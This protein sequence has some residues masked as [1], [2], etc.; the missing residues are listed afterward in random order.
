MSSLLHRWSRE[1]RRARLSARRT[2]VRSPFQK[3]MHDLWVVAKSLVAV[4]VVWNLVSFVRYVAHDNG[5]TTSQRMATWG[6]NHYMGSFIDWME[7]RVYSTPPSKDPAKNLALTAPTLAPDPTTT[8]APAG[9]KPNTPAGPAPTTT[10]APVAAIGPAPVAPEPI[11]PQI[12]PALAGEGQ[13]TPIARAAGHDTIWATSV[14][15]LAEAGG[16]VAT[17]VEIDQT[18]LRTGLFN[19]AEEPGGTWKRANRVPGELQPALLAA[20][21]GGFRFEHIKGGYKTEGIEVKP[22]K[23]GDA[24]LAVGTDGHVALGEFGRDI[25]DDGSWISFRQNLI[26]IVDNAKSQVQKGVNEG[27]WW[28]ADYGNA[29]YVPRS[30]ACEMRDGRLA[31]ALVGKVNATQLAQSLI[32]IGCVKAMQLDINGTW[33]VFFTFGPDAAG[34][35]TGHFVDKRMGGNPSRYLTGSTKEFFAFFDATLVPSPSVLDN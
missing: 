7:T 15:P 3:Q 5:D 13:W 2:K 14:R 28:G 25:N 22:L 1:R 27:V 9:Q 12:S 20:M 18:D 4:F 16:V 8:T 34:N 11:A 21:N 35:L 26:L 17:V 31:Y 19:G 6:R 29:V 32:N 30:A 33:P 10:L 24:T 23:Q